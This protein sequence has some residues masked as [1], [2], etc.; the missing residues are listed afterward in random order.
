MTNEAFVKQLQQAYDFIVAELATIRTGRANPQLVEDLMIES[1]GT[2][3][4]LQQ[5]ATIT[6]PES[7]L[8]LIQPWDP[9][10]IKNIEQAIRASSLGLNPVV[11][12]KVI[13]LPI[14]PLNEDRRHDLIK[15][16]NEKAESAKVRIRQA[17]DEVNKTL[18]QD[19][20]DGDLSEDEM[21]VQLKSIQNQVDE[22]VDKIDAV[23]AQKAVEI[24]TI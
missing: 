6:T 1:Y 24:N 4:P 14:P 16:A 15:V 13:R 5:L 11:D 9:S 18:R 23:L 8:L 19:Q 12:S 7:R 2:K 21:N 3:M 17:R 10:V 22:M 20:R